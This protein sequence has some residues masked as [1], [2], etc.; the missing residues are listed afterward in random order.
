MQIKG[1][2]QLLFFDVKLPL[3]ELKRE[4]ND[5]STHRCINNV[6]TYIKSVN[7]FSKKNKKTIFAG[8][9]I[10]KNPNYR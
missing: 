7:Q 3:L 6:K 2:I 4:K 1:F 9:L 5:N 8:G 10:S